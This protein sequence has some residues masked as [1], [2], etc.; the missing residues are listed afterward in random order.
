MGK[1]VVKGG[2]QAEDGTWSGQVWT[3]I[4][5]WIVDDWD[6]R[7]FNGFFDGGNYIIKNLYVKDFREAGLFGL[8]GEFYEIKNIKVTSGYVSGTVYSGII[9]GC[10]AGDVRM[11]GDIMNCEVTNST[12]VGEYAGGIVGAHITN[13]VNAYMS[14]CSFAR[15]CY[16][17]MG[18]RR[19]YS[20]K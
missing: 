19:N 17:N 18:C 7:Y 10:D 20:V 8:G 16:W 14:N 15:E 1:G 3:P 5:R 12:V 4:G 11:V 13:Y 9:L 6:T 2:V